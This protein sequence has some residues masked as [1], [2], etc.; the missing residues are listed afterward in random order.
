MAMQS[1]RTPEEQKARVAARIQQGA[2]AWINFSGRGNTSNYNAHQRKSAIAKNKVKGAVQDGVC[3]E[4]R[5]TRCM[6]ELAY[7]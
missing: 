6:S 3:T 5:G 7:S 1:S 4:N 2:E